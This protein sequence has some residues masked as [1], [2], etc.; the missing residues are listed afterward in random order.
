MGFPGG[1]SGKESACN[2]GDL[3]SIPGSG[4]SPGEGNGNPF[5]YS[6]LENPRDIGSWQ[7]AFHSV[8]KRRTLLK[9]LSMHAFKKQVNTI[10]SMVGRTAKSNHKG[11]YM[12]HGRI[13]ATVFINTL[14][15][16]CMLHLITCFVPEC[17]V[18]VTVCDL[19][20]CLNGPWSFHSCLLRTSRGKRYYEEM[21]GGPPISAIT[22]TSTRHMSGGIMPVPRHPSNWLQRLEWAQ[23]TSCDAQELPIWAQPNCVYVCVLS[24]VW[25]FATPWTVAHQAPLSMEFPKARIWEWVAISYSREY[26]QPTDQSCVSC[27]PCTCGQIL[28]HWA[29]WEAPSTKLPVCITEWKSD[30]SKAW[31]PYL[32]FSN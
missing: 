23:Q 17:T 30:C 6:C 24:H 20:L 7:A 3:D 27:I 25:P 13:I 16:A 22:V 19:G 11:A 28:Y 5:Q 26:S 12:Q 9:Q 15:T 8:A 29:T 4:R 31:A 1:A 32:T 21:E 14:P 2:A 18:E 10:C